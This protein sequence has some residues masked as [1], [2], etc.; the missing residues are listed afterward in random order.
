MRIAVWNLGWNRTKT[1]LETM[2]SIL[3]DEIRADIAL[4]QEAAPP[5]ALM[6]CGNPLIWVGA[7]AIPGAALWSA[8]LSKWRQ[9]RWPRAERTLLLRF[10]AGLGLKRGSGKD[11]CGPFSPNVG[12]TL[13]TN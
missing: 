5:E 6:R 11:K 4:L 10:L 1:Q 3:R 12:L 7:E 8:S 2:W 13:R 9:S